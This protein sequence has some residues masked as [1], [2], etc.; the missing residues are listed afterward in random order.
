MSGEPGEVS[1]ASS[2]ADGNFGRGSLNAEPTGCGDGDNVANA[3]EE[4]HWVEV[5]LLGGGDQPIAGARVQLD[6]GNGRPD[7]YRLGDDGRCRIEGVPAGPWYAAVSL[8]GRD[9]GVVDLRRD[10]DVPRAGV[11]RP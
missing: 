4:D 9:S 3:R 1:R 6:T 5:V 10:V 7:E 11:P 8:G 2:L